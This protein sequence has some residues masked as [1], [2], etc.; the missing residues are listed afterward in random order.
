ML[1]HENMFLNSLKNHRSCLDYFLYFDRWDDPR[2][3]HPINFQ[4]NNV[5]SLKRSILVINSFFFSDVVYIPSCKF[6]AKPF[7]MLAFNKSVFQRGRN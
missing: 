5:L 4:Q 7:S 6:R 1:F 2:K 3:D